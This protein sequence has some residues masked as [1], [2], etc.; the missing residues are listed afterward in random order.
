MRR[1][2]LELQNE[3]GVK[4]R[5]AKQQRQK[6]TTPD[7]TWTM[8]NL[9]LEW[10]PWRD[11]L[12][13]DHYPIELKVA[14]CAGRKGREM[15]PIIKWDRF[16]QIVTQ[17]IGNDRDIEVCIQEALTGSKTQISVKR[18]S[19]TPDTHL[20][21]LWASRLQALQKYKK[22][23]TTPQ[24]IKLNIATA[25]ATRY[26]KELG[27][28]RW[29]AH[30]G[31]FNEKTGLGKAWRTYRAMDGKRRKSRNAA[32]NL[33]LRLNITEEELA[34]R[35]GE[36]FF[37]QVSAAPPRTSKTPEST[38]TLEAPEEPGME[39]QLNMGELLEALY[40]ANTGSAPGPDGIT[41]QALRNLPEEA[42]EK[43]LN[44][45][46]MGTQDSLKLLYED[47]MVNK[48]QQDP[49][50][51]VVLDIKKAF[52]AVP[53]W[54][55]IKGAR[56]CGIQGKS[57][58]FIQDF[59]RG[60]RFQVKIGNTKGP[61]TPNCRGV[62]QGAVISPTLFN[63]VL[64]LAVGLADSCQNHQPFKISDLRTGH[65]GQTPTPSRIW[66]KVEQVNLCGWQPGSSPQRNKDSV[67]AL[68]NHPVH[69]Y[70]TGHDIAN[71]TMNSPLLLIQVLSLAVGL[72][73]SCQNHQPFKISDLRTGHPG[74]TPTP[75]RIWP[76]VEQVNL[77]GWQPGSSPQRNKD[78]VRALHNHPVHAYPT[79]HDIAN[80]TMNSPLLLIQV[81]SLA[82]GLAD[83]CQNHQPFKIS[84]LRTGH[85]GQTPTPSRIWPK[86]EQ[87]NLCGWQ[88]GSSPQRNKD[89]VRALHNHPVHAYPTGHDIANDTMNSPLLLIQVL[90]LAVGL[91]DSCQ[92]HQPFKISDLRT[93]H[94]GQTPTPSRIWP[95]VEQVNLC[96]W[97]PGSSP[98]RNK[99]SVRALH[100]HPVH[101]YPTGHDIANDTMNS[102]LLLIQLY[103]LVL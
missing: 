14:H 53:H 70:P 67:R 18:G 93:G 74:Q 91:A 33:A 52:D 77:C 5:L 99:D 48:N 85:P 100:N 25:K 8:G 37:P 10:K 78:S 79:G 46:A 97:Q 59:L 20:L 65:P 34:V 26:S 27:R 71:D 2:G 86:V 68:H 88:P 9:T 15:R 28:T 54:A 60:R 17:N 45:E 31:S 80:D 38:H 64:S 51:V 30:C 103:A 81:L 94:P 73:D 40:T 72:A 76:K 75:S 49:R 7:L 61:D 56:R 44:R 57:L 3:T 87:V 11:T 69:A 89:S 101:A 43:L 92:N 50:L 58:A 98:Q 83:S 4:T 21:N 19:P 32:Q 55:L 47:V 84:D 29:R 24:K 66:P 36:L 102:P 1:E 82:V 95:K 39:D 35:A 96:G 42:K 41:Y 12:G 16:R 6:D 22:V 63:M 13:S 90:S 62:P 23:R